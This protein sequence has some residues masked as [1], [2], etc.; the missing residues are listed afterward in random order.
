MSNDDEIK[1]YLSNRDDDVPFQKF[2]KYTQ[3]AL[4]EAK[5]EQ[6]FINEYLAKDYYIIFI[7]GST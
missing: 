7:F 3:H 5:R 1:A 2:D 4:D 6:A